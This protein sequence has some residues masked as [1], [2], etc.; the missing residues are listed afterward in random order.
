[1]GPGWGGRE[2]KRGE[3]IVLSVQPASCM[4]GPYLNYLVCEEWHGK[5]QRAGMW[6]LPLSERSEA[7]ASPGD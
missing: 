2:S 3:G 1:M 5:C 6:R 7:L 4:P